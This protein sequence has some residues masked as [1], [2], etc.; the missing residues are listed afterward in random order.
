MNAL[1]SPVYPE[2]IN[3]VEHRPVSFSNHRFERADITGRFQSYVFTNGRPV[4]KSM[5]AWWAF[6]D[7]DQPL[8]DNDTTLEIEHIYA[9]KRN[10]VEPLAKRSNLE[11]LGNKAILEKRVNIRAA[12]YRFSDKKKYYEGFV[13]GNGKER[14]GTS[15]VEL[16][17]LSRTLEDFTERDIENR[18][19]KIIGS[20]VDYLGDNGPL[21]D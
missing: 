21:Q 16:R 13:D 15:V 19:V 18:T 8:I 6:N 9:R 5:L 12:D 3:I 4:T 14:S 20:F 10:E 1:R 7:P 2:M 17:D 11:A